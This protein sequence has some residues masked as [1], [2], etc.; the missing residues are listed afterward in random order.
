MASPELWDEEGRLVVNGRLRIPAS[1]LTV[2]ATK[3]GGP[4]G[5]HVNTSSTRIEVVWNLR[6]SSAVTDTQRAQLETRLATKLDASGGIRVVAADTRSQAQNRA[7]A[8]G[9]LAAMLR[10]ALVVPKVRRATKPSRGQ[11]EQRLEEKKRRSHVKRD[12]RWKTDD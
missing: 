3:A 12:R 8:L 5:Q 2:R 9:R 4:G 6:R 11:R 1:E 7:L 10:D